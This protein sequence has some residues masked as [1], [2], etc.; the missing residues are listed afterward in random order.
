[1]VGVICPIGDLSHQLFRVFEAEQRTH[2]SYGFVVG[3][4][5]DS[6]LDLDRSTMESVVKE[7]NCDGG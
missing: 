3:Y 7:M 2:P 6:F 4:L 1:M 5:I